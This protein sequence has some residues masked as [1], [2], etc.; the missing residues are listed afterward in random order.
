MTLPYEELSSLKYTRAFLLALLGGDYKRVPMEV[1]Q[2][3]RRVLR[4][5]PGPWR[6]EELYKQ[7]VKRRRK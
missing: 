3:A 5:Y 1:R 2:E 4:H 7:P 6:L